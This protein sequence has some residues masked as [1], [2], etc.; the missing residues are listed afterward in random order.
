MGALRMGITLLLD[1]APLSDSGF[2]SREIYFAFK[3]LRSGQ[4]SLSHE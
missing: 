3:G 2:S 1:P 4:R